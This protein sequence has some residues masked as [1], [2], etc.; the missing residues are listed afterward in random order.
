MIKKIFL[1][2]ETSGLDP[3]LNAVLEIGCI[4][5]YRDVYKELNFFCQPF[6][7]D[8]VD[9]EAL[10]VNK[11][12]EEKIRSFSTPRKVYDDLIAELMMH[13]D[14]YNPKDKFILLGYNVGFDAQFLRSFWLK[15]QDKY[16]GSWFWY[17]PLDVM[18]LAFYVLKDKDRPHMKDFKLITV[19]KE[20]GLDVDLEQAHNA[21]YDVELTRDI[22]RIIEEKLK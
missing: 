13:V 5:E 22:Y 20:F 4:I 19:A 8:L 6:P 2:L 17:P 12:T 3:Q 16:F 21:L 9:S 18:A 1:D 7:N 14:K 11:L 15:N 10:D